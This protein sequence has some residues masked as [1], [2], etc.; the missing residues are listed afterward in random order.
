M[1]MRIA[2][3][4]DL[5]YSPTGSVENPERRGDIAHVLLLRAVH[6]LNRLVKPDLIVVGGD[7]LDDGDAADAPDAMAEVKERL[8]VAHAPTVVLPGNHDGPVRGF[9]KS[10][11]TLGKWIDVKGVRFVPFID[12]EEPGYNARRTEE[13]FAL[14]KRARKGFDGPLVALQHVPVFPEGLTDSPYNYTNASEVTGKMQ[15]YGFSM[16]LSGHYHGG[17][18]VAKDGIHY[19]CAPATCV[20]PLPVT[21]V[22]LSRDAGDGCRTDS[23][24][25]SPQVRVSYHNL[26]LPESLRLVD[27]HIH[28]Q[29]AYCGEDVEVSRAISPAQD[30][31]LAGVGFSEHSDQLYFSRD[32]NHQSASFNSKWT[33]YVSEADRRVD[34]YLEVLR[35]AVPPESVGFEVEC[36]HNGGQV[37][38]PEDA[39]KAGFLLGAMHSLPEQES[40]N[41]SVDRLADEFMAVADR[42]TA[43]GI[44]VLAHPF[45]IFRR[46]GLPIPSSLFKPLVRML[47]E[48][49][50]AAEINFHTN[51]PPEEFFR[52]CLDEGANLTFGSDSH[53]LYEVGDFALHLDFLERCGF[54]GDLSDVLIDPRTGE[55]I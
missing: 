24:Y 43:S 5:H 34:E 45:R 39:G 17:F 11:G 27:C 12:P 16:V 22:D 33:D 32:M 44:D 35:D 13:N 8:D 3:I 15:K 42:F 38:M 23:G 28:T 30:F 19:L 49:G 40:K 51:E 48:R 9:A 26:R 50:V 18:Y 54:D 53:N 1:K 25:P 47:Q 21:V 41:P 4:T 14:M 7:V 37:L 10:F 2:V 31:G 55:P 6:R 52:M 29:F 36:T 46:A 20:S